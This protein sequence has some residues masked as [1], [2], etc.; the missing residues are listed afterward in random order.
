MRPR[1]QNP[2][3]YFEKGKWRARYYDE[4]GRRRR[5]VLKARSKTAALKEIAA[6]MAPINEARAG[7]VKGP[8]MAFG[9]FVDRVYLAFA[10]RKWKAS[11]AITTEQRLRQHIINGEIAAVPVADLTREILQ[12]FLDSK[13]GQSFS[14]VNHLRWDFRAICRMAVE[15]GLLRVDP[16]PSLFTPETA[17][18]AARKVMTREDVVKALGALELRERLF[19]RFALFAGLRP[20]EIIAL[21]WS[22]F[23][24]ELARVDARIYKGETDRPKGRKGRNTTRVA[25][26][27]SAL[28][29]DLAAWRAFSLGKDAFV[30]P[31]SALGTPVK[32]ENIWQRSIRPALKAVGLGWCTF[33]VMRR[34]W[35]SLSKAAGADQQAVADQ[36]GHTVK[37]DLADYSQSAIKDRV[38]A[39]EKFERWVQ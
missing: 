20:G 6:I 3:P 1:H 19:V 22:S 25:A 11:T 36:L 18:P 10:R 16:T 12:T 26:L 9:V 15:D 35:S 34:T 8:Q 13:R 21:R 14:V 2:I 29:A 33:Q 30:F 4:N 23:D 24:A 17:E 32:Y 27:P 7:E 31:S 28:L 37:V 38:D 5:V 39:V